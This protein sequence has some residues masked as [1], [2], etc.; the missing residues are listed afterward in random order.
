MVRLQQGEKLPLQHR[1]QIAARVRNSVRGRLREREEGGSP[2]NSSP[3][4]PSH[5]A[6]ARAQGSKGG[7]TEVPIG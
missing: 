7:R 3:R 5:E 4:G 2:D 1:P 6:W